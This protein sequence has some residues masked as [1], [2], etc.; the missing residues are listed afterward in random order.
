VHNSKISQKVLVNP[1]SVGQPR[2]NDPRASYSIVKIEKSR[3]D[4]EII[5]IEYK[6]SETCK[7][8]KQASLDDYLCERLYAGR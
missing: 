3:I 6:I 7:S 2:D 4:A 5:R 8:I 1:G